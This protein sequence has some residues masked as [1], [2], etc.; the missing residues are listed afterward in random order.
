MPGKVTAPPRRLAILLRHLDTGGVER[1]LLH[2]ARGA[3]R[4]GVE[5]DVLTATAPGPAAP[6]WPEGVGRV[7]LPAASDRARR[8]ALAAYLDRRRPAVLLCAKEPD[9]GLALAARR[10]A[11]APVRLAM[12][13]VTTPSAKLGQRRG[14]RRWWRGRLWG[15][16]YRRADLQLAV[17]RG[18][19]AD[20]AALAGLAPGAVRVLPN[21]TLPPELERLARA[22]VDHP[23]LDGERQ[24]PLILGMG[25]LARAKDFPT[26]IRAFACLE[27][28][29]ARLVIL[30][31][32]RQRPRLE[33]LVR[34]LGLAG[35]VRLAGH[36]P[37]PYAWLAR[38]D[39]FV[40]SS[41]WEG[42]PNALI[43]ALALGVPVVATDCPSG[44]AEL[45]QGGRLGPLVPVGDPAALAA[46]MAGVLAAPPPAEALRAAAGPYR[47]E[48]AARAYLAA[49]GLAEGEQGVEKH[50]S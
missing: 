20:V 32:G 29:D 1:H 18:V 19:A 42:M 9:W 49:L 40:L 15:R 12:L 23:W 8:R 31:E 43:E 44:P 14:L 36:Q 22:P 26:L 28:P 35:R 3:A 6:P 37:N 46:A 5:V 30:G 39:L 21:P 27:R 33:R 4:A 45:L 7:S 48:C 16:C 13:A 11:Q 17:S 34:A 24:G 47:L 41:R 10:A 38:A 25:R 50:L 2:L